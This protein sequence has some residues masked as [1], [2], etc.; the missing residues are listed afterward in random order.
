MSKRNC[1]ALGV[2]LALVCAA[3][4]LFSF[5]PR[6]FTQ[7]LFNVPVEQLASIEVMLDPV[8]NGE[9]GYYR[10]TLTPEDNG[11]NQLLELLASR[12]YLPLFPGDYGRSLLMEYSV[13][14]S[15]SYLYD[16]RLYTSPNGVYLTGDRPIMIGRRNYTVSRSEAFQQ[17]V[18]DLVL[19]QGPEYVPDN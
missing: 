9:T 5:W 4:L 11:F 10:L 8:D 18:L 13:W 7:A 14:I 19:A 6:S 15:F 2:V 16:G 1:I 12:R 17:T 3:V